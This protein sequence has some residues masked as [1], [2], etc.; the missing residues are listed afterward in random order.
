MRNLQ[1][2]LY[3][4]TPIFI[5]NVLTSWNGYRK[6][7]SRY[8]NLYYSFLIELEKR[9]YLNEHHAKKY[10]EEE[11]Q[12]LLRHAIEKSAFYKELYRNI[13]IGEI[14]TVADL[15]EL[16]VLDKEML[17]HNIQDIYTVSESAAAESEISYEKGN[18][19]K[20]L[21]TKDDVQKRKAFL[22]FFKKQHGA[23]NLE[24]KRASFSSRRIIPDNQHHKVF[25]RDNYFVRQRIYSSYYCNQENAAVYI[26]DLEKYKPDFIDGLPSAI[27]E[28][29]K[30]INRN[31]FILSFKPVAI[32]SVGEAVR[33]ECR[34]EI[35][36]AFDCPLRDRYSSSEAAPFVMECVKGRMHYNLYSGVIE[37]TEEGNMIVTSFNNY[38]TPLIRYDIGD[39]VELPEMNERCECGSVHPVFEK[40]YARPLQQP[41]SV[42]RGDLSAG[43]Y[44]DKVQQVPGTLNKFHLFRS[45]FFPFKHRNDRSFFSA[46]SNRGAI[47]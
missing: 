4:N 27:F 35:E 25:W 11:L 23:V 38:G 13:D 39:R 5:Q 42:S 43:F 33:P 41:S 15:K 46:I 32:F 29:A 36:E 34:R 20:L 7:R 18:I 21:Y 47:D 2:Q 14:R 44:P 30:Y 31:K 16:P 22:D 37:T 40:I 24:M 9:Q 10:Q 26:E 28:L 19:I 3:E 17:L 12:R 1:S 6:T 45:G 8:G